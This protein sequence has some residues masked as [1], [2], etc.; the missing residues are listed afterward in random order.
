MV[1]SWGRLILLASLILMIA[2]ASPG[3]APADAHRS[4]VTAD[5]HVP[6]GL[7]NGMSTW[8]LA[9]SLPQLAGGRSNS[10]EVTPF[11]QQLW[12]AAIG[13]PSG[14]LLINPV[15]YFVA[16]WPYAIR[17]GVNRTMC[18]FYGTDDLSYGG[19]TYKVRG[20]VTA[21]WI[22]GSSPNPSQRC[23]DARG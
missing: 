13:R 4:V 6:H 22:S 11:A 19:R 1:R 5:G 12:A 21:Y 18:V 8:F 15:G 10:H 2:R 9:A 20:I 14:S 7:P 23:R 16:S 17:G 3:Y